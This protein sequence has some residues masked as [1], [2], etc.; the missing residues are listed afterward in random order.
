[1]ARA[2]LTYRRAHLRRLPHALGYSPVMLNAAFIILAI[3][4]LL[5][6]ALAV[7]HLRE[8]ASPP[9]WPLGALHGLVAIVGLGCLVLALRGPPRG[10]AQGAGSFGTIAAALIALAALA[11]LMQLATRLRKKR[12]PGLLIGV[13]A[14]L[15]IV[16]FVILLA[17]VVAA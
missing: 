11:G 17:Y 6:S 13:H 10:L 2:V 14:T 15:A 12:P 9:P 8:D 7:R 1:M 5:G 4:V 16:G 3:A